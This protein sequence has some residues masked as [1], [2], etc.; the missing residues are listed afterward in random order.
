MVILMMREMVFIHIVS[1]LVFQLTGCFVTSV[2]QS[3][4]TRS[5]I[6]VPLQTVVVLYSTAKVIDENYH[7]NPNRG[8]RNLN[9][10]TAPILPPPYFMVES[11]Y[12]HLTR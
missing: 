2:P 5:S 1:N 10:K 9:C 3:S 8:L 4:D 12:V 6:L 7:S 11:R